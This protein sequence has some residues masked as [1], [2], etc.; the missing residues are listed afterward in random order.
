MMLC[1]LPHM[2]LASAGA[3]LHF[4]VLPKGCSVEVPKDTIYPF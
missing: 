2:G 3:R 4:I 1:H